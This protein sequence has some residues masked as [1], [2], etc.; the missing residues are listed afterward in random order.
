MKN[1]NITLYK[2][3]EIKTEARQKALEQFRGINTDH[4]WWE[5]EY[6]FFVGICSTMGIRTSPQEI[7]FRGFYSQGDGSC[8]SSRINVVAMLKAVERQEWKNHIPNL[9][10]DL[11]PCDID[12]RVLALIENATIEV[13]TCTKTSHRYY[14]IQLDLEWRYYGND[15][16]NFSRIDSELLKLETWV[17]ITLK[18]LNGYLYESLRDTYEHLTGDTAVQEAIEANEY[19]FTTEGIYADWIFDKAQ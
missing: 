2:F 16:R 14:C 13:P 8:F 1:I 10:L 6:D 17:M 19:H 7:F 11:I 5:N 15:N 18:K 4:N 3:T 9:E 12:R